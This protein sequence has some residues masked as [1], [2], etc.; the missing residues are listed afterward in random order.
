MDRYYVYIMGNASRTSVYTGVTNN[1]Q[2]RVQEHKAGIVP[3][4]T[5]RYKCNRLLYYEDYQDIRTAISR[6]KQI[7]GWTRAKKENLIATMNPDYVDLM[8]D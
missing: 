3:G 5:S 2:R 1:L 7:K 6:E 4:F 8:A